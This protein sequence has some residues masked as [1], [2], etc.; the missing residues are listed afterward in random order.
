MIHVFASLTLFDNRKTVLVPST[1]GKKLVC[2]EEGL[3]LTLL[4]RLALGNG[5]VPCHVSFFFIRKVPDQ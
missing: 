2:F 4:P 3:T 1:F 5:K